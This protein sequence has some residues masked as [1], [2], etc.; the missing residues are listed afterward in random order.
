MFAAVS[1]MST[2]SAQ[3]RTGDA[4]LAALTKCNLL[5]V[6]HPPPRYGRSYFQNAI[7]EF[8]YSKLPKLISEARHGIYDKAEGILSDSYERRLF[9]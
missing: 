9:Q 4:A 1:I 6:V 3:P 5:P 2:E 8:E 7:L